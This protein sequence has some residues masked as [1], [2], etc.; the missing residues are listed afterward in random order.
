MRPARRSLHDRK[1]LHGKH[2]CE[3]KISSWHYP[4]FTHPPTW[5]STARGRKS[6]TSARGSVP[7]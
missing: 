7:A 4:T 1:R 5:V 3:K 6:R 2:G